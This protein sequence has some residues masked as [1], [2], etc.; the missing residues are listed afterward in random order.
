MIKNAILIAD[1]KDP[2]LGYY[3]KD[4]I[5]HAST[6]INLKEDINQTFVFS[7]NCNLAYLDI[8]EFPKHE[9]KTLFVIC[10]HGDNNR[11]LKDNSTPFIDSTINVCDNALNDG[12]IYSIACSTGK[13]FGKNITNKN[14]SFYGYNEEISILPDNEKISIDCD[15]YGL[16]KILKSSNLTDAREAARQRYNHYIDNSNLP[17]MHKAKLRIARDSIVIHGDLQ[18]NF[19]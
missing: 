15:N 13:I 5:E 18:K 1:E 12:L 19:F 16:L 3:F 17:F 9:V 10:S 4:C 14:A 2:S 6:L 8:V 11:F 7:N